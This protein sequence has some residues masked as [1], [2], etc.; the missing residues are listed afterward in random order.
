MSEAKELKR[1]LLG[2]VLTLI[3]PPAPAGADFKPNLKDAYIEREFEWAAYIH[4][5]NS[6]S[7]LNYPQSRLT[8]LTKVSVTFRDGVKSPTKMYE[9]FWYHHGKPLGMRRLNELTVKTDKVGAI[10]LGG[11]EDSADSTHAL[12][13]ALMRLLLDTQLRHLSTS[14]VI[15]PKDQFDDITTALAEYNFRTNEEPP[16][17]GEQFSITLRSAPYGYERVLF[18]QRQ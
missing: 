18:L 7:F 1:I 14:V 6:N 17:S 3:L 11:P 12:V 2:L 13:N 5:R 16:T 9:E 10:V 4:A 8:P 15:I